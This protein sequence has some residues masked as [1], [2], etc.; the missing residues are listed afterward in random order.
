VVP[1]AMGLNL[2]FAVQEGP[3]LDVAR[4]L[5]AVER[6][7][8][9]G[10]FEYF[11]RVAET[12]ARVRMSLPDGVALIGFCG[13]P[14]TV[15]SYI[16]EGRSSDRKAALAAAGSQA[17]WFDLLIQKL[18]DVSVIYLCQQI[19]AGAEAIQIF[20]SWAGDLPESLRG[21]YVTSPIRLVIDGVRM[22]YRDV[23]VIVFARGIGR[24][25]ADVAVACGAQGVGVEQGVE[26]AALV[27]EL[28][29]GVA[30]QGNLDPAVM[31]DPAQALAPAV[32]AVLR[33]VPMG[34][35]IFNLGHGIWPETPPERVSELTRIVR[36]HDGSA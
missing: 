30:V 28:P 9:D 31:A 5:V 7:K 13:A 17:P 19:E 35:H 4:D 22:R 33:G 3:V 10:R 6:L 36:R 25:H 29:R 2:R 20:D 21:K 15:A 32:E 24:G 16:I 23:P 14:W 8:Y 26:L 34:R 12:V 27:A 1:H 11:D 18:V